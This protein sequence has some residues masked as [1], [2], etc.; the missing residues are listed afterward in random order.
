MEAALRIL[1][2]FDIPYGSVE[3][4]KTGK[5]EVTE[6]TVAYSL[7]DNKVKYAPYGYVQQNTIWVS[8]D[9][10]KKSYN[11]WVQQEKYHTESL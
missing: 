11:T 8:T 1:H 4:K 6:Y 10:K 3:D 7:N 5:K 2:N 9:V